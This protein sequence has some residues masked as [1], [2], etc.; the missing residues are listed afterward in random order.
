MTLV[1]QYAKHLLSFRFEAK[2]SRESLRFKPTYFIRIYDTQNPSVVGWGECGLFKGLSFDDKAEYESKLSQVCREIN[3]ISLTDLDEWPSIKIG[4]ETAMLD[5]RNGGAH[6]P[7]PG[8]WSEGCNTIPINGLIWMGD[9]N[10]MLKRLRDKIEKGFQCIKLKIGGIDFDEELDILKYIRK[11][12]SLEYLELRLDANG[13][14][15]PD[16]ALNRLDLLSQYSIHSIEQPIKQG[17]WE[18]MSHICRNSPINIAL[19]EELIGVISQND[20]ELMLKTIAPQYI[21]LK[22]TLIGGFESADLWIHS[23]DKLGIGWWAT[24]ALESNIGLNAIA[25]WVSHKD[26]KLYQGLGTGQLY[27]NN[28][29]SPLSIEGDS[30][31]FDPSRHWHLPQL[32]WK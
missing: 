29:I 20:R 1:A 32:T 17:Q 16:N 2:T 31:N 9:K 28:V 3:D 18:E 24:S 8:P 4:I 12:F 7:F 14:F 23:A 26:N 19:D 11:Q 13:A 25:Q 21:I 27:S 5:L 10:L 15:T 22:P 30:L 6:T